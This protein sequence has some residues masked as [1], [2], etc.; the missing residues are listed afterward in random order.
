[1]REQRVRRSHFIAAH[2][3]HAHRA[4]DSP[5][6]RLCHVTWHVA[7]EARAYPLLRKPNAI[8]AHRQLADCP[9]L[10]SFFLF[11]VAEP[12]LTGGCRCFVPRAMARRGP[13]QER[14][15]HAVD[16][17]ST[18]SALRS[19][20]PSPRHGQRAQIV[21]LHDSATAHFASLGPSHPMG[22]YLAP[23]SSM[24]FASRLSPPRPRP[25]PPPPPPPHL[26]SSCRAQSRFAPAPLPLVSQRAAARFAA[27]SAAS[28]RSLN[29]SA[30]TAADFT[31]STFGLHST[32][33]G[34]ASSE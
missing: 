7:F 24:P 25:P 19:S 27:A 17:I 18:A 28:C 8:E 32:S 31:G 34:A 5:C 16:K 33:L 13:L 3:V 21:A 11:P 26:R 1:M 12:A 6:R 22:F 15:A 10:A 30:T 23:A 20:L 29:S 2:V 14:G 4:G 9:V